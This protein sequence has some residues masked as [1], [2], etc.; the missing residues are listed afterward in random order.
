MANDTAKLVTNAPA[1][2]SLSYTEPYTF[3]SEAPDKNYRAGLSKGCCHLED[4]SALRMI[5]VWMATVAVV[6]FVA[7][8]VEIINQEH[9]VEVGDVITD[10]PDCSKIGAEILD[11][12]GNAVDAA[13]AAA[14]CLTVAVPP[15][16]TPL[17]MRRNSAKL[18]R[19]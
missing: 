15:K 3:S 10:H 11:Q 8:V 18:R 13:V 9:I 19:C 16:Q 2:R 5:V 1:K 4:T 6:V 7:L 12:G 14:L 17:H